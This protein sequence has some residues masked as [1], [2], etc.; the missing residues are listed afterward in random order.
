MCVHVCS[1]AYIL[2]CKTQSL[3]YAS[4]SII[5]QSIEEPKFQMRFS[6]MCLLVASL[7]W[8]CFYWWYQVLISQSFFL[9]GGKGSVIVCYY[10]PKGDQ[11]CFLITPCILILVASNRWLLNM[12]ALGWRTHLLPSPEWSIESKSLVYIF[13]M[14]THNSWR[15]SWLSCHHGILWASQPH[16]SHLCD[17]HPNQNFSMGLPGDLKGKAL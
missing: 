8:V 10:P 7:G 16:I 11:N 14:V 13:N 5:E 4:G 3:M 17:G 12:A 2:Q 15:L 6:L 9:G 1:H